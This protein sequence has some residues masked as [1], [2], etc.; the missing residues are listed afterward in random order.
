MEEEGLVKVEEVLE[1]LVD[2][3]IGLP[4][5]EDEPSCVL[6]AGFSAIVELEF[7]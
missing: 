6:V 3:V 5:T 4:A 1:E 7:E 2:V